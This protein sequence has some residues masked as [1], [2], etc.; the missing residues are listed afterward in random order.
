[1]FV[2]LILYLLF[3]M[4]I[5]ITMKTRLF[6]VTLVVAM[7]SI[8]KINA[9]INLGEKALG[10]LQTGVASFTFSDED[11]AAM[12]KE[13]VR[14][15]DSSNV[16]AGPKDGY[17]LRLNRIFGK[18]A[19]ENGLVLNYKVYLTKDVNAFATADGSVRV[20]SGLMDIMDDNQLLAVIGH[21]IGH[22]ANHDSR[23]AMKVALRKAALV[24]AV[25]SQSDK[26]AKLTDSQYGQ[27]ASAIIDSKY[28][29]KQ[30]SEADEFSYAFLKRNKYNVNAE[31]SAFAILAAMSGGASSDFLSKMMSSHPDPQERADNAKARATADGLYKPYVQMKFSNKATATATKKTNK[32][33]KK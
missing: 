9:Q 2:K 25:S 13:A 19:N 4:L 18:H 26:A 22:V 14:K 1:M 27:L 24:G 12:S 8:T 17:T 3:N 33:K 20:F 5:L 15:M 10:A 28:S 23:D 31:E 21:E 7:F 32:K 11:A 6:T 16:V 30:E 29:R